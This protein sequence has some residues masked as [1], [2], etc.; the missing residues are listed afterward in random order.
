MP[1]SNAIMEYYREMNIMKMVEEREKKEQENYKR[2]AV[3]IFDPVIFRNMID[4]WGIK[5]ID[6]NPALLTNNLHS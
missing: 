2:L 6:N 4:G 5:R 1:T 3:K